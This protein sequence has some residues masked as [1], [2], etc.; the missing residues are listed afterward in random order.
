MRIN[1]YFLIAVLCAVSEPLSAAPEGHHFNGHVVLFRMLTGIPIV[2]AVLSGIISVRL[3]ISVF[4]PDFLRDCEKLLDKRVRRTFFV[5][6]LAFLAYLIFFVVCRIAIPN[7]GVRILVAMPVAGVLIAHLFFGAAAV[8]YAVGGK[9]L[10]NTSSRFVGSTFM[11]V[12]VG[13]VV[14]ALPIFIP[15]V[16]ILIPVTADVIGLGL[17]VRRLANKGD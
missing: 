1:K 2:L 6:F 5:G 13:S 8:A 16:G 15:V 14:L 4:K 9:I 17:V 3:L 7:R 12:L 11:S 10:A